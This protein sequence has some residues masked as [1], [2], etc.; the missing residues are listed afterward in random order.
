MMRCSKPKSLEV[1]G[2]GTCTR[3]FL[4]ID[5]A[6][7]G[8]LSMVDASAG[9]FINIGSGQEVSILDLAKKIIA[10][11]ELDIDIVLNS[12]KPD[13]QPRKVMDV[14]KARQEI[15]FEPRVSLEDG[16]KRTVLWYTNAMKNRTG[17]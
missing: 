9:S 15:G 11:Y 12:S 10:A 13:G 8:V 1:W 14:Q 17:L 6:V 2:T 16:L 3:E 7:E 5:D 4:Y